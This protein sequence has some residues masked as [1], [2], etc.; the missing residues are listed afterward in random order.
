[1]TADQV[2]QFII[3]WDGEEEIT[4]PT[5]KHVAEVY[6]SYMDGGSIFDGVISSDI[7]EFSTIQ[8]TLN[9]EGD[10]LLDAEVDTSGIMKAV[11]D[12]EFDDDE[13]KE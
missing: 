2:L 11:I 4:N 1:M 6:K 8:V 12:T 10:M 9:D 5:L 3:N 13:I 7:S